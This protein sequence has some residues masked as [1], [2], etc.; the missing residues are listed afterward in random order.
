MTMN[1]KTAY[2]K[3]YLFGTMSDITAGTIEVN[4]KIRYGIK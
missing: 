3:F 4:T 2:F 1:E